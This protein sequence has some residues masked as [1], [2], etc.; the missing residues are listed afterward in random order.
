VSPLERFVVDPSG[1]E[2]GVPPSGHEA[3]EPGAPGTAEPEERELLPMVGDTRMPTDAGARQDADP[4][5]ADRPDVLRRFLGPRQRPRAGEVCELCAVPIGDDHRHLVDVRTQTL[6]CSCRGCAL[7]FDDSGTGGGRY[8]AVPDRYRRLE[9]FVLD[10]FQWTQ[11]QIP[12]GMA[13]FMVSTPMEATVA[14]YPSPGGA[15]ESELPL[16]TWEAIVAANPPLD[17]VVPDVEAI[18]IRATASG[19]SRTPTMEP[20][21]YIVPIDRC[22]EL[23][24]ELRLYWRGFDGGQ[25]VR[26]H[27]EA[28]FD[29]L[30]RRSK[31]VGAAR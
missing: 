8:T 31:R 27:I 22:Y 6:R 28:F 19:P 2:R 7:L 25:E 24:G 17:G 12:V 1:R 21:C 11:L 3:V 20:E 29:D 14:F 13:F 9:P 18:L 26:E 30:A 4:E 16:D 23:V 10:P 5:G 15:T